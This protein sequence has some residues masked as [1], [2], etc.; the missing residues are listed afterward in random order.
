MADL[1]QT[2]PE[3]ARWRLRSGSWSGGGRG[4]IFGEFSGEAGVAGWRATRSAAQRRQSHQGRRSHL[5]D[6]RLDVMALSTCDDRM[7]V[8]GLCTSTASRQSCSSIT[9]RRSAPP[10][11][12][13][14]PPATEVCSTSLIR[15][16]SPHATRASVRS[17][18]RPSPERGTGSSCASLPDL[19]GR[20]AVS[21]IGPL[22]H[23]I[24]SV[25]AHGITGL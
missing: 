19:E 10:V 17:S 8:S 11:S 4:A 5:P 15:W 23:E 16:R 13:R 24:S 18:R 2:P 25:L 22:S 14:L 1:A 9:P 20:P 21:D 6:R 7:R 3:P 12:R